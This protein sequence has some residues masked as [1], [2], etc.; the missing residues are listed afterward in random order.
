MVP[1]LRTLMLWVVA[2]DC[3]SWPMILLLILLSMLW[4]VRLSV[5]N[6]AEILNMRIDSITWGFLIWEQQ[7]TKPHTP[8]SRAQSGCWLVGVVSW[9]K[10]N[11]TTA[12][13][14]LAVA[15]FTSHFRQYLLGRA[16]I[17]C[18][19]HSSI[20]W[21]TRMKEPKGQLARWLESGESSGGRWKTHGQFKIP[22]KYFFFFNNV[23]IY[24]FQ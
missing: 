22:R 18:A 13:E 19:D 3:C 11:I 6:Q 4:R 14:L 16:F 7:T 10:Q 9:P 15:E 8:F 24:F 23:F 1:F 5:P 20:R 21:L 2:S 17:V 12:P